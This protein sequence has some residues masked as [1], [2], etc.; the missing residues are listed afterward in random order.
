MAIPDWLYNWIERSDNPAQ[1]VVALTSDE[2]R[3]HTS[4]CRFRAGNECN[5][6]QEYHATGNEGEIF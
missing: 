6:A 2:E 4:W 5:C 1:N 3:L